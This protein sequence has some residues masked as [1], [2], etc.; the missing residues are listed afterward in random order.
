MKIGK[1]LARKTQSQLNGRD[2]KIDIVVY[3]E[4]ET[5]EGVKIGEKFYSIV[6]IF[7]EKYECIQGELDA[8]PKDIV[9]NFTKWGF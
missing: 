6:A 1:F 3:E 8:V 9:N 5:D 4:A 2:G 7:D